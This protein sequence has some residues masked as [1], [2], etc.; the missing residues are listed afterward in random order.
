MAEAAAMPAGLSAKQQKLFE[1]RMRMVRNVLILLVLHFAPWRNN[2]T[3]NVS[4]SF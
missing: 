1:L 3:K 4:F 2:K